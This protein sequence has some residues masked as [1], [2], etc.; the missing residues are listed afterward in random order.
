[1]PRLSDQPIRLKHNAYR[2]PNAHLLSLQQTPR[3]DAGGLWHSF[4]SA[5]ITHIAEW[6]NAHLPNG[7]FV[8]SEQSLQITIS[9]SAGDERLPPRIPD[10]TIYRASSSGS[11]NLVMAI[12]IPDMV[13]SIDD[14]YQ[15]DSQINAVVI[16]K[17]VSH[18]DLG[19]PIVRIEVLSAANK[20]DGSGLG[21]YQRGRFDTF[22]SGVILYELD[23]LHEFASPLESISA[24]PKTDKSRPYYVAATDPHQAVLETRVKFFDVDDPF[25]VVNIPLYAD[26]VLRDFDFGIPYNTTFE[27]GPWG[28]LVDYGD[29]PD[30]TRQQVMQQKLKRSVPSALD[31]YSAADQVRI[32]DRMR[33]VVASVQSAS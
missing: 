31:T 19:E 16:Y 13:V 20:R 33:A 7:Y 27:L 26:E 14:D 11:P 29:E 2:G 18:L 1:M 24:Y 28:R 21:A 17:G 32:M 22:R 12:P 5:F 6:L 8:L 30:P 9:F 25:P 15:Q 10:A 3:P 4:H 23:L